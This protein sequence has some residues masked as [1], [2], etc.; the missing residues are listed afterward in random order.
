MRFLSFPFI[1]FFYFLFNLSNSNLI[2]SLNSNL[3]QTY[4]QIILR[5]KKY[6]FGDIFIYIYCLY[7][8]ILSLFFSLLFQILSFK[9]RSNFP[10]HY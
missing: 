2:P 7:F 8:Y 1:L 5:H 4:P 10:F 3:C 9:F 6:Q